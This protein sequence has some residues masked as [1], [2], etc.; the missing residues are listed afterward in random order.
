MF[1]YK[2]TSQSGCHTHKYTEMTEDDFAMASI[3]PDDL[4][5]FMKSDVQL[6]ENGA[7]VCLTIDAPSVD[8][9]LAA[10]NGAL[11][12]SDDLD[13]EVICSAMKAIQA[14]PSLSIRQA[15]II[16]INEWIK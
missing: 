16:G 3:S 15:I 6:D 11:Y 9:D 7:E 5:E 12:V 14:D 13:A 2:I 10:I 4:D 1:Y 8:D